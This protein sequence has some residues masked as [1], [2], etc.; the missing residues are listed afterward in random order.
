MKR[1]V[2]YLMLGAAAAIGI[3][4]LF[5]PLPPVV[6]LVGVILIIVPA[7]MLV[8]EGESDD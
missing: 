8:R 3:A 1:R 4:G 6:S 5:I 7:I 2:A